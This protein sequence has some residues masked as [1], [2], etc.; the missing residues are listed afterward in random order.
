MDLDAKCIVL[1]RFPFVRFYLN[2]AT[3]L[4]EVN[5]STAEVKCHSPYTYVHRKRT[6][7]VYFGPG[8]IIFLCNEAGTLCAMETLPDVQM[9]RGCRLWLRS[10][11]REP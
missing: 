6:P 1:C 10:R 8:I 4:L 2:L 11:Q 5:K 9:F 7:C 3:V